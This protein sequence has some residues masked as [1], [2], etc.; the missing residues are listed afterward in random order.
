M[1]GLYFMEELEMQLMEVPQYNKKS[2]MHIE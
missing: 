2:E 1:Q